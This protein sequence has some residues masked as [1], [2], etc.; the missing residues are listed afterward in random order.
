MVIECLHD[1]RGQQRWSTRFQDERR[2]DTRRI[3]LSLERP[4]R[5]LDVPQNSP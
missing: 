2:Q 5:M 3:L 4:V 1:E